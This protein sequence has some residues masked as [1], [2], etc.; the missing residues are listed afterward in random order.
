M[1]EIIFF[2]KSVILFFRDQQFAEKNLTTKKFYSQS[3]LETLNS[4]FHP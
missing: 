1:F 2:R 3:N 4:M